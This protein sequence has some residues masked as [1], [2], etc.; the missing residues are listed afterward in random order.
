MG[1]GVDGEDLR[2]WIGREQIEHDEAC[3]A[4]LRRLAA[5][6][7]CSDEQIRHGA[8]T[9]QG[10]HAA[11]FAPLARQSDLS[12][13]GHPKKGAFLPPSAYPR[14]MFAGRR[15]SFLAPISIGAQLKR[16]SRIAAISEK[17]GRSGALMIV[18][19]DHLIEADGVVCVRETHDIFYRAEAASQAPETPALVQTRSADA[20][21]TFSADEALLFRYSAVTFN[22][23]R[24][25]YDHAYAAKT[26]GY[27]ALVV[28]GGLIAL[29]LCEHAKAQLGAQTLKTLK[30]RHRA[31]FF[32]NRVGE[33]ASAR[34][35]DGALE[36]WALDERG[37]VTAEGEAEVAA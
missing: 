23:H 13:D 26:E 5:L 34:R 11:F 35:E 31:P 19:V 12:A 2:A 17:Q 36:L 4:V 3:P 24:I 37:R 9:P 20:R 33:L 32:V 8:P 7:D 16:T 22:A 21:E 1:S 29:K 15:I 25:H 14:R 18:E 30:V 28:N 27:P 10:W 6:L